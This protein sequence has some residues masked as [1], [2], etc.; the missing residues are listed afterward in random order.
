SYIQL[1]ALIVGIAFVFCSFYPLMAQMSIIGEVKAEDQQP[2][3][4]ANVLLL[5]PT[6]S[7]LVLGT[8]ANAEGKFSLDVQPG[9]YLINVAM[10]GYHPIFSLIEAN[11]TLEK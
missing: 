9:T 6:D 2:I 11:T 3:P 4:F 8:I 5:Q 10:M 7:A 1:S